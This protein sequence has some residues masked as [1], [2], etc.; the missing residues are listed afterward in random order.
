MPQSWMRRCAGVQKVSRPTLSCQEMSQTPPTALQ[1][2]ARTLHQMYQGIV[3]ALAET[4]SAARA[5]SVEERGMAPAIGLCSEKICYYGPHVAQPA[6]GPVY[7]GRAC[8][9]KIKGGW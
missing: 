1:A 8:T 9:K 3:R 6:S 2:T 5:W 7:T 4:R